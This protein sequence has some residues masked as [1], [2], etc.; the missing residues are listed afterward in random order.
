MCLALSEEGYRFSDNPMVRENKSALLDFRDFAERNK[1]PLVVVLIPVGSLD[2]LR[3]KEGLN[4][5]HYREVRDFLDD[6]GIRFVD[7]TLRFHE[8][9]LTA[10]ETYWKEDSHLDPAGNRALAEILIEEFPQLFS[11]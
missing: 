1:L 5:E 11:K 6:K 9:G 10:N 3:G 7:L 8:R 2:D 4:T